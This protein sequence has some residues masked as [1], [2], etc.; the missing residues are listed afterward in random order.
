MGVFAGLITFI[1]MI[2]LTFAFYNILNVY[3]KEKYNASD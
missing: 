2:Y 1:S 3:Y